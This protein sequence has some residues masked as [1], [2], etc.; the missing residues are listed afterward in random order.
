VAYPKG[1]Q[2]TTDFLKRANFFSTTLQ[3]I[4]F[5]NIVQLL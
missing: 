1:S 4:D 5:V 2:R 3:I